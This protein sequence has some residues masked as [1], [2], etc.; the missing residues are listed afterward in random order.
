MIRHG[1]GEGGRNQVKRDHR[2]QG[3]RWELLKDFNQ[4][5]DLWMI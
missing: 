5:N 2:T 1:A 4:G 3:K